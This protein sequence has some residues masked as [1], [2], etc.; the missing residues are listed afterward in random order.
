MSLTSVLTIA[1]SALRL[2]AAKVAA[3]A[4]NVANVTTDGYQAV[5]VEGVTT[6]S[7]GGQR[8]ADRGVTG[9]LRPSV[10]VQGLRIDTTTTQT[11]LAG[12]RVRQILAQNAYN[13]AIQTL[14]TGDEML[15]EV[16]DIK[17]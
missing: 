14:R 15:G 10:P 9:V 8:G 7:G 16:I 6:V 12:E 17:Q 11:D 1:A 2:N 3:S 13:A 5:T 4:D